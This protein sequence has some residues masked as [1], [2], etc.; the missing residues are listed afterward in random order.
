[1]PVMVEA[2]GGKIIKVD[3]VVL[4]S[5]FSSRG[6]TGTGWNCRRMRKAYEVGRKEGDG[7]LGGY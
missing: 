2:D 4:S 7:G 5:K 6:R 1:M 3:K